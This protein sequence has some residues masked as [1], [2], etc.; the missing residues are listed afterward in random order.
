MASKGQKR[1]PVVLDIPTKLRILDRLENGEKAVDIANEFGVGKSTVSD[2]K[3][4]K[5]KFREFMIQSDTDNAGRH[6]MKSCADEALDKALYTWFIQDSNRGTLLS[7]PILKEKALWY[8]QQ[9]HPGD[10]SFSPSEGWLKHW[11]QRHG[12]R[13]LSIPGE[14]LSSVGYETEPFKQ[15][16]AEW[17]VEQGILLYWRMMPNKT[18]AGA[19]ETAVPGHKKVKD[20]VSLLVCPNATGSHKLPPLLI[21]KSQNPRCFKHVKLDNLPV[22]YRAQQHTWMTSKIFTD[23]FKG[24]FV[25]RV[26]SH[27]LSKN[28]PMKAILLIDNC[29]AHP[30]DLAVE[31]PDGAIECRFLPPSTTSHLQ[32]MDQGP[33][34]TM[35]RNYR[36]FLIQKLVSED[37]TTTLTEAIKKLTLKDTIFMIDRAWRAVKESHLQ[38]SWVKSTLMECFSNMEEQSET[39]ED[40]VQETDV[41]EIRESLGDVPT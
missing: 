3:S 36:R 14:V 24:V 13:Q 38:K 6:T 40:D 31:T 34:E 23:W 16:L 17:M 22:V 33:L 10:S 19:S 4:A 25:P 35:K 29:P 9:L 5:N 18:L 11:K 15:A 21:G 26:K 7:G 20:S 37:T 27:L 28:L 32:A 8:Y 12:I 41:Q 39:L 1:K 2:I 30:T